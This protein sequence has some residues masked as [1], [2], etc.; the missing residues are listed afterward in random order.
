M[1]EG[2]P[3]REKNGL[4]RRTYKRNRQICSSREGERNALDDD[5]LWYVGAQPSTLERN[6]D[7]GI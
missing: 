3:Q 7:I 2:R 1:R 6:R 4:L 5:S